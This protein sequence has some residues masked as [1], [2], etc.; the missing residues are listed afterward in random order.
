MVDKSAD[1]GFFGELGEFSTHSSFGIPVFE[2][3]IGIVKS[4]GGLF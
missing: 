2:I 1:Y 4:K 3:L